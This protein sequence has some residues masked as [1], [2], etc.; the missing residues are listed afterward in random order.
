[1]KIN[2][3]K[4][5]TVE[6]YFVLYLAALILLLPTHNEEQ[7]ETERKRNSNFQFPISIYPDKNILQCKLMFD[8]S[9]NK[10]VSLD[11]SNTIY[12]AG[13]AVDVQYEFTIEDQ[14]LNQQITLNSNSNPFSKFFSI[15]QN[16]EKQTAVFKWSPPLNERLNK[17]Y[18]VK[19]TA[20][21]KIKDSEN[22]NSK[23]LKQ[24]EVKTQF[25]LNI[26]YLNSGAVFAQGTNPSQQTNNTNQ[27]NS[28]FNPNNN[29]QQS[30]INP[31]STFL[32]PVYSSEPILKLDKDFI[33]FVII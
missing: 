19:V 21:V 33:F 14:S 4:R 1:M 24:I 27:S 30:Q 10:V 26:N 31:V 20:F 6:I 32:Q 23:E 8:S 12:L 11:S 3:R 25:S 29:N 22:I 9:S 17:V 16:S 28:N 7:A 2:L 18:L 13:N 5:R 15:T